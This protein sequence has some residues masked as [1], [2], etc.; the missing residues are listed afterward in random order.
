MGHSTLNGVVTVI[1]SDSFKCLDCCVVTKA[2]KA[3]ESWESRKGTDKYEQFLPHH[4]CDIN[5]EGCS[6]FMEA[7]S[8]VECF[9]PETP[10]HQL[11]R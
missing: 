10:V 5:H 7:A 3:R 11:Y 2:F 9:M 1:S 4:E 8:I 6:D